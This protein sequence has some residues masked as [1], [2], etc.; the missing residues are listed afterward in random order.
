[1]HPALK[2]PVYLYVNSAPLS[3]QIR[4]AASYHPLLASDDSALS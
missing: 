1:M 4:L 3:A 2:G